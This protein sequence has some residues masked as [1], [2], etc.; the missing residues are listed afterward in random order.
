MYTNIK[1]TWLLAGAFMA[2]ML[3]APMTMAAERVGDPY[4]LGT[5][6]VSGKD[7]WAKGEAI[8]IIHEGREFKTCCENCKGKFEADPAAYVKGVDA[9]IIAQQV[10]H[11][12]LTTCIVGGSDLNKNGEPIQ[13]VVNNRLVQ[14]CCAGC[15][16]KLE[17][18]PAAFL[19]KLDEAVIAQQSKG[20]ALKECPVSGETLG[21]KTTDLIIG[22]RLVK[23]CCAGC[24]KKVEANPAKVFA[25]LDSGKVSAEGSEKKKK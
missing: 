5:C 19:A 20:Y 7:A 22:N 24:K 12:P 8:V 4:P 17:A 13:L 1:S 14:L 10:K 11:Y 23:L 15:K 9:Q 21:E 2:L 3:C 16:D 25:M 6:A 18:D